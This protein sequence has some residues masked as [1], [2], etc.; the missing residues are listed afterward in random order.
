MAKKKK[1]TGP[2]NAG[3][4]TKIYDHRV[5]GEPVKTKRKEK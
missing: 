2:N 4:A 5:N 3:Q 1:K